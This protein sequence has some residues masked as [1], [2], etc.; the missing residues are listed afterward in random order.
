[1]LKFLKN[2]E[3]PLTVRGGSVI[4]ANN[5][6]YNNILYDNVVGKPNYYKRG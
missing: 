1:V 3:K 2:L 5:I 4:L 6:L